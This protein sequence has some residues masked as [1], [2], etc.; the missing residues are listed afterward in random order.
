MGLIWAKLMINAVQDS[1][2]VL[3]RRFTNTCNGMHCIRPGSNTL[4]F[5]ELNLFE[6]KAD[7]N[8]LD[9]LS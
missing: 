7:P 5:H 9:Q 3:M 2:W 8:Y 1:C 6:I 4:S